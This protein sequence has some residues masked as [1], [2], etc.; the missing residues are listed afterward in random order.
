[1]QSQADPKG[2]LGSQLPYLVRSRSV[3][4]SG[5][6]GREG[7]V[8]EERDLSMLQRTEQQGEEGSGL[9]TETG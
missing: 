6:M 7:S 2:S 4:N 8:H 9:G 1:M 5:A 3:Q